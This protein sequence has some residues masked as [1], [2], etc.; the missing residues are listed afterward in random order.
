MFNQKSADIAESSA[1]MSPGVHEVW[2]TNV[3]AHTT[4][5]KEEGG[6]TY[7]VI[8]IEVKNSKKESNL[9]RLFDPTKIEDEEKKGKE[10]KFAGKVITAFASKTQGEDIELSA[11]DW[12]ELGKWAVKNIDPENKA[13]LLIK[14]IGNVWEGKARV[15]ITRYDGWLKRADSGESIKLSKNENTKNVEWTE[16]VT[17]I[18]AGNSASN[19]SFVEDNDDLPF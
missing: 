18:K 11:K 1:P 14:L 16:F 5:P 7:N 3:K 2:V 8:D 4:K 12:K 6:T 17:G 13:K 10:I 15:G 19:T 9:I